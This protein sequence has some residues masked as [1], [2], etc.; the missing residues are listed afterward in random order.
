MRDASEE[1]AIEEEGG[2]HKSLLLKACLAPGLTGN[3]SYSVH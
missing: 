2:V 3:L 1:G